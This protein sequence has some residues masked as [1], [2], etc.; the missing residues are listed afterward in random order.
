MMFAVI[1]ITS[2]SLAKSVQ[3]RDRD[4]TPARC[5]LCLSQ[6]RVETDIQWSKIVP[7]CPGPGCSGRPFGLLHPADVSFLQPAKLS[8]NHP[9]A[10]LWQGDPI[11]ITGLNERCRQ[12]KKKPFVAIALVGANVL[13]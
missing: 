9:P 10:K 8:D 6:I 1:N 5:I 7:N 12:T 3:E 2:S 11:N 13:I 4:Y